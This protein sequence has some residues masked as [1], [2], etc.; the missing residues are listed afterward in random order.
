MQKNDTPRAPETEDK[1][2]VSE[3]TPDAPTG[4]ATSSATGVSGAVIPHADPGPP[5]PVEPRDVRRDPGALSKEER[6]DPN[7][8]SGTG[9]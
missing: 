1:E 5:S 6:Q 8:R 3:N 7:V 2:Q 4:G 9:L